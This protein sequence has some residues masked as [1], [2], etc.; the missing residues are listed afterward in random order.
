MATAALLRWVGN[1]IVALLILFILMMMLGAALSNVE[2]EGLRIA[3]TIVIGI[4][5][6]FLAV[7]YHKGRTATS[8]RDS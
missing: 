7:L 3:L 5:V 2:N 4:A 8:K 1:K 6:L